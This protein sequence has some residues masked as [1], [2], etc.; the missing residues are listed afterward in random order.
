MCRMWL[1]WPKKEWVSVFRESKRMAKS[2]KWDWS[3]C[4][5][6]SM[7]QPQGLDWAH[8]TAPLPCATSS[9]YGACG[10]Q[11]G[12]SRTHA[13]HDACPRVAGVG[14]WCTTCSVQHMPRAAGQSTLDSGAAPGVR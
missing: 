12:Q 6:N 3:T 10:T 2:V 7:W 4:Q 5:M 1:K 9:I 13:A 8:I 11:S 14:Q